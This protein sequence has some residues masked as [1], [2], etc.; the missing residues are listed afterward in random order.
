[1]ILMHKGGVGH[2][3]IKPHNIMLSTSHDDPKL[4]DFGLSAYLDERDGDRERYLPWGSSW[5]MGPE[6]WFPRFFGW[7]NLRRCD[8]IAL[9]AT[10]YHL[11][12]GHPP[13]R[14]DAEEPI[15]EWEFIL[16]MS[17]EAA[18]FVQRSMWPYPDERM[19]VED[20]YWHPFVN[21]TYTLEQFMQMRGF[22]RVP[23]RRWDPGWIY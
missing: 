8:A 1:V 18:D 21:P 11:L 12:I 6:Q 17:P 13:E 10:L 20:M 15:L 2:K 19:T 14:G 23:P 9:G 7:I 16:Y 3:D 22:P 5:F 4:V